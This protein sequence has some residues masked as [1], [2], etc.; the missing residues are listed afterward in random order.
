VSPVY[1]PG[2]KPHD[3]RPPLGV[4]GFL[5][6]AGR[7]ACPAFALGGL[8]ASRLHGLGAAGGVAVSS[9]VWHASDPAA[10]VSGLLA[11]L[12]ALGPRPSARG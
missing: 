6:L 9:A 11:A 2:S 4:G 7:L 5:R 8:D 1:P 10:A 12:E 3:D